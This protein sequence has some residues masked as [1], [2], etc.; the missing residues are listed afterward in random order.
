MNSFDESTGSEKSGSDDYKK[1][2]EEKNDNSGNRE[3]ENENKNLSKNQENNFNNNEKSKN[4]NINNANNTA[5][6]NTNNS[7]NMIDEEREDKFVEKEKG[8]LNDETITEIEL[9]KA[10]D[11]STQYGH[12]EVADIT[13]VLT[14]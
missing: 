14:L 12:S 13:Y 2:K 7:T 1:N 9:R 8:V 3:K 5:N 4:S 11:Q 10:F 6:N